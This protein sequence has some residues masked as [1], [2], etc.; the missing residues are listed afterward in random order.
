MVM[1][2]QDASTAFQSGERN[3]E[4]KAFESGR[5]LPLREFECHSPQ[6]E[7]QYFSGACRMEFCD[8]ADYKS[9]LRFLGFFGPGVAESDGAVEDGFAGSGIFVQGEIAEAFELIASLRVCFAE[10]RFK[11]CGDGFQRIRVQEAL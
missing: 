6:I 2:C 7:R 1:P 4:A 8:T 10:A 3:G 5:G 11:F 9:A